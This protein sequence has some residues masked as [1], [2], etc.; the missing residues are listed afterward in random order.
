MLVRV[1]HQRTSS[2]G[3]VSRFPLVRMLLTITL[4]YW[5]NCVGL[6]VE[7]SLDQS[8]I[9]HITSLMNY[10]FIEQTC[11]NW[12]LASMGIMAITEKFV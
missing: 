9:H 3:S 11:P 6:A 12:S 7:Y 8:K 4:V 5:I 1:P 10:Q 2:C